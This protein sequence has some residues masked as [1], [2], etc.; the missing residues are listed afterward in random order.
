MAS[1]K[2]N[3]LPEDLI[4]SKEVIEF[5][6]AA[7]EF[8]L[9]LESIN[10]VTREEFIEQTYKLLIL[11]QLKTILLP[12][13]ETISE[14][15]TESFIT[16]A[17]WHFID[18]EISTKLGS[19]EIFSDLREPADPEN[20]VEISISEC[21]TDTYQ[22]I[23]D[24]TQLYQ[25]GNLEAITQG[26][27]ECKTNFEQVWGPRIMIVIREFHMLLNGNKDLSE[28]ENNTRTANQKSDNW[29]DDLFQN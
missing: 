17:D 2:K 19:F 23:K 12:K 20:S 5:I 1:E 9:L 29:I 22:D 16:E 27:R 26:L 8:C 15:Q 7:N 24:F 28:E 14:E 13:P 10:T 18:N 6:T 21:L 3:I 25:F 4:Y 11:L